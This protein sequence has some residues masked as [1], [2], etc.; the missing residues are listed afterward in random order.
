M[1]NY[2]SVLF[3]KK[4]SS[5][6]VGKKCIYS[7]KI[8]F[9]FYLAVSYIKLNNHKKFSLK[10]NVIEK[11][12]HNLNI[13]NEEDFDYIINYHGEALEPE[14]VWATNISIVYTWVDGS[15]IDYAFIKSKYNGGNKQLTHRDRSSDELC[16][17]IRSLKKYLPWHKGTI[18]IVTDNQIPY[19]LNTNNSQIKIINHDEIIPKYIKPTFDS[20]TIEC[21]L[22]KIPNISEIFI[23]LNDD[24]FFNN[25]IHP[26]FFFT[27]INFYPKFYRGNKVIFNE[28][29][30]KNPKK[31]QIYSKMAYTTNKIIKKYFDSNFIF[32]HILHCAYV[33]YR[34][35]FEFFRQFFENELRFVFSYRFRS[36]YKP[37]T[38]YLYQSLIYYWTKGN[39]TSSND[40]HIRLYQSFKND[41]ISK[42]SCNI[43]PWHKLEKIVKYS[44]VNDD[45]VAN[46]KRFRNFFKNNNIL[47]YNLND[48][49]SKNISL[50]EL[51]EYMMVRYPYNNSFEKEDY[52]NL[53]KKYLYKLN[54]INETLKIN[55]QNYNYDIKYF[56]KMFFN[57]ENLN[58]INEYISKRNEISFQYP[59]NEMS[60]REKD[61]LNFLLNYD[62]KELESEW[63]WVKNISIVYIIE[64]EN[65][66]SDQLKYSLGTIEKYLP[67]F[68]GTIFVI[69]SDKSEYLSL[70]K[71][72][73]RL[74]FIYP[75]DIIPKNFY[76]FYNKEII[77]L[78]LDKIPHITERF[79][80]LNKY[81]Y[82]K[83]MIHPNFFFN[84]EFFPKYPLS[85]PIREKSA[86]IKKD[87]IAFWNTNKLI[88]KYFGKNYINN[89][90]LINGPI[91]LYRDLFEPVRKL[92]EKEINKTR[93]NYYNSSGLIPL[94][95]VITYNIY[96][97]DQIYYPNYV[98]GFGKIRK[99]STPS[100]N[101]NR[102]IEYY[103]FDIASQAIFQQKN[104]ELFFSS[105]GKN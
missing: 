71:Y 26:S 72:E 35:Y 69:I 17:S 74:K 61:E 62:G 86:K 47:F 18:F 101:I 103:G 50:Y 19:W 78:Y 90:L 77:E 32:Y 31:N 39:F 85:V 41:S 58:Y 88:E 80:Y 11:A 95:L 99:S 51:T 13:S 89:Y 4:F 53:E 64:N 9:I 34:N 10:S 44:F 45:S 52:V 22:D 48:G 6:S 37:I 87:N 91:P 97:T 82:F 56:K 63:D 25:Y 79:I 94:Y 65:K 81:Y 15:D 43:V 102:T 46:F 83:G 49:Y 33:C 20:S 67:W 21:F 2:F 36:P 54:Y 38:I 76:S 84:K 3:S 96:G 29:Q 14:W 105:K 23:Y 5:Y 73:K 98:A 16:Y 70:K 68:N 12:S 42:Y 28:S 100:L 30:V 66:E 75:N 93:H 24:F 8:A 57:T 59:K 27:N 104:I 60:K 40:K 92:Y 1:I 55:G 7:I